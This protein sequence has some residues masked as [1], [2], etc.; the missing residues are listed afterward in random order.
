MPNSV[1]ALWTV[2]ALFYLGTKDRKKK[3]K[4]VWCQ[5]R[6]SDFFNTLNPRLETEN[7]AKISVT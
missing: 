7:G 6:Y 3:K 1:S 2:A 4:C 5:H